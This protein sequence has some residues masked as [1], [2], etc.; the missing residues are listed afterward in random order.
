MFKFIWMIFIKMARF[1]KK[2]VKEKN[3]GRWVP[4]PGKKS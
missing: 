4:R 2:K 1:E 3:T